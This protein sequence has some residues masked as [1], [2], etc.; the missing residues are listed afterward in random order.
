MCCIRKTSN[1]S[2]HVKSLI[3]IYTLWPSDAIWRQRTLILVMA[4]HGLHSF[5]QSVPVPV[6][7]R[8]TSNI[9]HTEF[10]NFIVSR[11]VVQLSLPNPSKPGVE[12]EDVAGAPPTGDAPTTSEWSTI[13]LLTKMQLILEV[14]RQFTVLC[15]AEEVF[16]WKIYPFNKWYLYQKLKNFEIPHK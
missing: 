9:S 1:S 5:G 13:L 15:V 4:C 2:S 10:P 6:N 16:R 14:W 8:Q 11:L 12:N 7:Y 3:E